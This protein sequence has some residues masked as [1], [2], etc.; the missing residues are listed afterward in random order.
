MCTS[1][2]KVRGRATDRDFQHTSQQQTDSGP[3]ATDLESRI[4]LLESVQ[5]VADRN[6]DPDTFRRAHRA[7]Q[8]AKAEWAALCPD[9]AQR[10]DEERLARIEADQYGAHRCRPLDEP[11]E[12]FDLDLGDATAKR[13]TG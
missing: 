5:A 7:W 13:R 9:V 1:K 11:Q 2:T 12:W 10:Q 8:S 4:R 3:L 6:H